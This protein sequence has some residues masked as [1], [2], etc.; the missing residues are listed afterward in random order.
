MDLFQKGEC[1]V[2]G[3]HGVCRIIDLETRV[4]DRKR[5]EY[6][7]LEPNDQIGARYYVPTEN[8]AATS[9]L[10]PVITERELRAL[11]SSDTVSADAWISDENQ[12]KQYYRELITSGN[13]A[14]LIQMIHT[15]HQQ[16]AANYNAGKKFHLCDENF[17]R[18]AEKLLNAE[19][20]M[21]LGIPKEEIGKHVERLLL[22]K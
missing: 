17:L 12:R 2:Y 19:F 9:K 20:S 1:V 21:V 3:A 13:R 5:I 15:L 4:I 14:A 18:D 22:G 8:K 6:Y 11:L 7:V 16:R 10:S